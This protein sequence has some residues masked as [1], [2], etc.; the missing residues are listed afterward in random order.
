MDIVFF[1]TEKG[2]DWKDF[3][4]LHVIYNF[5]DFLEIQFPSTCTVTCIGKS[6]EGRDIKVLSDD[7]MKG[8]EGSRNNTLS[9]FYG[10]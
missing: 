4:P 9:G 7:F 3:Y 8:L 1:F 5:M 10:P 6:V 2:M